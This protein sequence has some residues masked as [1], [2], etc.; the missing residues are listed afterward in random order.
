LFCIGRHDGTFHLP[1]HHPPSG[2]P[3]DSTTTAWFTLFS[4]ATLRCFYAGAFGQFGWTGVYRTPPRDLAPFGTL[5]STHTHAFVG[6]PFPAGVPT[7]VSSTLPACHIPAPPAAYHAMPA[8]AHSHHRHAHA[9][10]HTTPRW[11]CSR[12]RD[13]PL[14]PTFS[15]SCPAHA[16][17]ACYACGSCCGGSWWPGLDRGCAWCTVHYRRPSLMVGL[18]DAHLSPIGLQQDATGIRGG[19][20][21]VDRHS[22]RAD[23]ITVF[24]L[25]LA[26]LPHFVLAAPVLPPCRMR[27][28][29]FCYL[30]PPRTNTTFWRIT[31]V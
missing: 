6:M 20:G 21:R 9:P 1:Y 13:T 16:R 31:C 15:S 19:C 8:C 25:G 22:Q 28:H 29:D 4:P 10:T 5:R 14:L 30:A 17:T 2:L 7:A 12:V 27:R 26:V 3:S 23:Q 11:R 18:T 24:L